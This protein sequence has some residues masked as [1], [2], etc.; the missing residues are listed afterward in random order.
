MP[1]TLDTA[2]HKSQICYEHGQ[3]R[4]EKQN[5]NREK[6]RNVSDNRKTGSNLQPYRKKNNSFQ[7]NKNFN[8][9]GIKPYVPAPNRNK[10]V[11]SGANATPLTIKCWKCNGSHYA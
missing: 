5:Q 10:H 1:K 11:L 4:Q 3:L 7:V 2:L 6:S 8:K 9:T